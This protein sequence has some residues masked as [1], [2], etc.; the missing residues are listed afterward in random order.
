MAYIHVKDFKAGLDTRRDQSA[1]AAGVLWQA[2][3]V[4]ISRGGEVEKRYAFVDIGVDLTG[5]LGL[6]ATAYGLFVFVNGTPPGA[7]SPAIGTINVAAAGKTPA[8]ILDWDV[9]SGKIYCSVRYTDGAV[10]HFYDGVLVTD[11]TP[12]VDTGPNTTTQVYGPLLTL[13]RKVYAGAANILFFSK[14]NDATGWSGSGAGQGFIDLSNAYGGSERLVSFATYQGRLAIFT[15]RSVQLRDI[16]VD[17]ANIRLRQTMVNIGTMAPRSVVN[18]GDTDVFFLADTGVRS[19]KARDSS[20]NAALSDIGTPIDRIINAAVAALPQKGREALGLIEPT[21][22]RYWLSLGSDVYVFSYFPNA[23][24]SAWSRYTLSFTPT[25][26]V[27][28][29]N[30]IYARG[31]DNRLYLYG[32]ASGQEYGADYDCVVELALLSGEK[33]ATDKQLNGFDIGC[34]GAWDISL[35]TDASN[36]AAREYLGQIDRVS[37]G[38]ERWPAAGRG[39]HFGPLLRHRGAGRAALFEMGIHFDALDAD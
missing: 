6:A 34:V 8:E 7:L 12:P 29:D 14:L 20:N 32:G 31:A 3:N 5:T 17:P 11:W 9:F 22:G 37:W 27:T 2:E 16:D 36:I 24:V 1:S 15:R 19:L 35:G 39:T 21:S 18:F 25:D 26:F 13:D 10:R 28:L 4:H 30:Q 38:L 23:R 33:P